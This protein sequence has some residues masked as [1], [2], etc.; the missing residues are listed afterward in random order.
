MILF[1]RR[2]RVWVPV[3][4][5]EKKNYSREWR[6]KGKKKPLRKF[7]FRIFDIPMSKGLNIRVSISFSI[8]CKVSLFSSFVVA[9]HFT[10]YSFSPL[11]LSVF[12]L[13]FFSSSSTPLRLFF[14]SRFWWNSFVLDIVICRLSAHPEAFIQILD[15]LLLRFFLVLRGD[16]EVL[17]PRRGE[18]G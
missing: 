2:P 18:K 11:F 15:F 1:F 12:S 6:G 4:R 17:K 9:K 16:V 14:Y 7:V 5:R 8:S 10:L 3:K 13:P